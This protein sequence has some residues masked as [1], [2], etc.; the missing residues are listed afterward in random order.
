MNAGYIGGIADVGGPRTRAKQKSNRS[1]FVAIINQLGRI[2][3]TGY[4]RAKGY[5][6]GVVVQW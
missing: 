3:M 2:C 6:N 1:L 4:N 5:N